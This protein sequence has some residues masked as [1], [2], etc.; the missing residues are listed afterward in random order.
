MIFYCRLV[1]PCLSTTYIFNFPDSRP[2]VKTVVRVPS[3]ADGPLIVLKQTCR[4]CESRGF[5]SEA[6]G[7]QPEWCLETSGESIALCSCVSRL[8]VYYSV[9]PNTGK[10]LLI[11]PY[12]LS[13]ISVAAFGHPTKWNLPLWECFRE[14]PQ[15]VGDYT[16]EYIYNFGGIWFHFIHLKQP[17]IPKLSRDCR[18]YVGG[19]C[20]S[21]LQFFFLNDPQSQDELAARGNVWSYRSV[22]WFR[23]QWSAMLRATEKK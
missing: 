8:R 10:D 18:F 9:A 4:Y 1:S 7:R 5:C 12:L 23:M 13:L 17:Q 15:E 20:C 21:V 2:E 14:D 16:I 19:K 22:K 11:P 6:L 3:T